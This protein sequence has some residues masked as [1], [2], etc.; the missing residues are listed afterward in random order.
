MTIQ[1][2]RIWQSQR[3]NATHL[4]PENFSIALEII[5]AVTFAA[6]AMDDTISLRQ[7][8]DC[9]DILCPPPLLPQTIVQRAVNR[10]SVYARHQ[11]SL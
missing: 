7:E 4:S 11:C 6:V 10:N 9:R 2:I 3:L 8:R 5:A 1:C